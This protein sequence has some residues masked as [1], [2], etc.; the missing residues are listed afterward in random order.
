[1]AIVADRLPNAELEI[2]ECAGH[3]AH[4]EQSAE[5]IG[6]VRRFLTATRSAGRPAAPAGA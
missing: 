6:I 3:N 1:M 5:V 2:I 4:D